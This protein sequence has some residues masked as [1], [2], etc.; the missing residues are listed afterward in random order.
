MLRDCP[1]CKKDS[2]SLGSILLSNCEC[3]SCRRIIGVH[4]VVAA[5]TYP[6]IILA[7]VISSMIVYAYFGYT[8]AIVLFPVP[9][10]ALGY[11]VARYSPLQVKE[12]HDR[13]GHAPD[14]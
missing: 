6:I 3:P 9:L 4:S 8:H 7:A 5:F 12:L 2:I 10:G 11:I 1:A 13:Q 14:A